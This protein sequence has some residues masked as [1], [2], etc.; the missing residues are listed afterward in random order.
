M[1]PQTDSAGYD[2]AALADLYQRHVYALLN[3][4]RRYVS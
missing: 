2:D 4:I 1:Q 3:F